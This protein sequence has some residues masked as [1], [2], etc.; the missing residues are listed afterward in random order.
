MVGFSRQA[1]YQA[2]LRGEERMMHE[3]I[4]VDICREIRQY[5]RAMGGKKM[6]ELV[7]EKLRAMGLETGIG[8]D[9][10]YDLLR[11]HGMLLRKARSGPRTTNS[12]HK[13]RLYTNLYK[14]FVPTGINQAWVSDITY[15]RI[16][17]G[18]HLYIHLVTDAYSRIIL[19]W[20]LSSTLHASNTIEALVM[21]LRTIKQPIVDRLLHHSDRGGQYCSDDYVALAGK[22]H[23][24][25]SMTQT[26]DPRDNAIA[27]RVNGILKLEY[28]HHHRV[29]SFKQA[30]AL[31]RRSVHLYC[32]ERPHLSLNNQTP[33]A[34]HTGTATRPLKRLWKKKAYPLRSGPPSALPDVEP[35]HYAIPIPHS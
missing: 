35:E 32:C 2:R 9:A 34:V 25:M 33:H 11:V 4:V 22:H 19:G 3:A 6:K 24:T 30:L 13:L 5:H 26:S 28:L 18:E 16:A 10:I 21:A 1:Y 20:C 29:D 23:I 27:E 7:K 17:T 12:R 8:R 14:E 15:W 31:L